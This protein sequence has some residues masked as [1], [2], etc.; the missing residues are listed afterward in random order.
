MY[1]QR[2][3]T[4]WCRVLFVPNPQ[5]SGDPS[6]GDESHPAKALHTSACTGDGATNAYAE[7]EG[8]GAD[9]DQR[10]GVGCHLGKRVEV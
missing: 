3:D 1:H 4:V 2:L 6:L 10:N 8:D 9:C 7:I 5:E